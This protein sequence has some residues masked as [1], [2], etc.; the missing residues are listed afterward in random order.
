MPVI[1]SDNN[2][3]DIYIL[4]ILCTTNILIS[5][6]RIVILLLHAEIPLPHHPDPQKSILLFLLLTFHFTKII[7]M[8]LL[9]MSQGKFII[10]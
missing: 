1:F 5:I 6:W 3:D 9:I 10:N 2:N 8:H 7:F 4:S